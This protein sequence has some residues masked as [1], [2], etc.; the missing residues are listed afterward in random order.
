MKLQRELADIIAK[1]SLLKY[2]GNGGGSW[3]LERG[4]ASI[5]MKGKNK[6]QGSARPASLTLVPGQVMG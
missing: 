4:I 2:Y 3:W 5:F 6:D 1:L